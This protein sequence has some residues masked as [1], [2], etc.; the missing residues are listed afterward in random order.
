MEKS[1]QTAEAIAH[2]LNN[3][4][5]IIDLSLDLLKEQ[6]IQND[7]IEHLLKV[8]HDNVKR[9]TELNQRLLEFA[10]RD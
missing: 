2:E 9:G 1:D 8:A 5:M 7:K 6:Y 3:V 10:N 4:L